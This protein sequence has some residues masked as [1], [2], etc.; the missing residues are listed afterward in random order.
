M[1]KINN[2]N[3]TFAA[4]LN[5]NKMGTNVQRW[6]EISKVFPQKT[7]DYPHDILELSDC[8]K[9]LDAYSINTKNG[10]DALVSIPETGYEKLLQMNNDKIVNTFKKMFS[11]FEYRDKEFE[12]ATKATDELRQNNNST[13]IDKAID[14]I[15]DTT[16]D[17]VQMHKDKAIAGDEVLET[18]KFYI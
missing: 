15:W 1:N 12:K 16:V 13:T 3:I 4:T 7:T 9:D 2:N 17:R 14:D 5:I 6:K 10:T 11:I 18:A 8:T